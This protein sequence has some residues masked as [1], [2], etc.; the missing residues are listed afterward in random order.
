MADFS[1][2]DLR[3]S[4]FDRVDLS[5]ARLR[6]CDLSGSRFDSVDLHGAVLRGV[7][8]VDV[9]IDGLLQNVTVNGVD[10]GPLVEAELDR[11]DPD[12]VL[13]RP[14]DADGFRTAWDVVER[15]WAATVER[16]RR[17]DPD[18]LHES[19]DG[20]W[21]FIETVRHLLCVTDAWVRRAVQGDPAPWHPLDL[22][23]DDMPEDAG[24]PRDRTVRPSLDEVLAVRA[25]RMAGVRALLAG[26]TDEQLVADVEPVDATGG[27]P[28]PARRPVSRCLLV[29][30]DEEWEHRRFAERDLAV[31]EA[32]KGRAGDDPVADR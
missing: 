10:V 12:R 25:D 27:W 16:A 29:V 18:Q 20:E 13:M 1:S 21:S 2:T 30:L 23:F 9:E 7:E 8:L 5:G 17:L 19:V 31:L 32:S 14:T 24:V 15:R 6:S 26:L 3:G 11:R 4:S 22:P 28:P